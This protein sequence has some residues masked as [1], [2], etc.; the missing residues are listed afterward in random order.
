LEKKILV[1]ENTKIKYEIFVKSPQVSIYT[2][3]K[4]LSSQ[5]ERIK[6]IEYGKECC[7]D[8]LEKQTIPG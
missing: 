3:Y 1:N 6:L 5:E 2:C 7:K 8:I 4:I